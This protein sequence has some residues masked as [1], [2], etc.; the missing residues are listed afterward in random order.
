VIIRDLTA[1]TRG[2]ELLGYE[3]L[4]TEKPLVRRIGD[5]SDEAL[6]ARATA[7]AGRREV[8]VLQELRG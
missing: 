6:L 1:G 7:A 8:I 4:H 3:I 2:K 5:E